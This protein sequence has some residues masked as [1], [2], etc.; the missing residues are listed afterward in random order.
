MKQKC[1][2]CR[3]CNEIGICTHKMVGKSTLAVNKNSLACGGLGWIKK[4]KTK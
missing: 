3:F 2:N 4:V 1:G